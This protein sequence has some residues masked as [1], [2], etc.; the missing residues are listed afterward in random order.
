MQE[1]HKNYPKMCVYWLGAFLPWVY[2]ADVEAAK[3]FLRQPGGK[4]YLIFNFV[5]YSM[6][7]H[8]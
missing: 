4:L 1:N 2:V 6:L 8:S 3:V 7:I 5:I